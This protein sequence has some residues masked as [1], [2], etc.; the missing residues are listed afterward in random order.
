MAHF[1]RGKKAAETPE[2]LLNYGLGPL[3]PGT[4]GAQKVLLTENSQL[5]VSYPLQ[6]VYRLGPENHNSLYSC[7]DGEAFGQVMSRC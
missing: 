2:A 7:S 4:R 3:H 6:L 1:P 5:P